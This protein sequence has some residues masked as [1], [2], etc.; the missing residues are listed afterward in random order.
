MAFILLLISS[1]FP[2]AERGVA[3][4]VIASGCV[5]LL[6]WVPSHRLSRSAAR[7]WLLFT[8]AGVVI[9]VGNAAAL[10]RGEDIGTR[11]TGSWTDGVFLLG[12]TLVVVGQF[13]LVSQRRA[14][15]EGDHALD[16]LL[17]GLTATS[18]VA[19]F[20]VLPVVNGDRALGI[21]LIAAA[22]A[23]VDVALVGGAARL[24]PGRG[25]TT[26][27]W[28]LLVG[29]WVGLI[30]LDL[31]PDGPRLP[32]LI[33]FVPL[34]LM[35]AAASH[36]SMPALTEGAVPREDPL[37]A[38]RLALLG[39][40]M[41]VPP[42]LLVTALLA[43]NREAAGVFAAASTVDG[44]MV[45][46]RLACLMRSKQ[47][48]ARR[49]FTL[50]MLAA[51][52][53][54]AMDARD[55][56]RSAIAAADQI[57]GPGAKTRIVPRAEALH[58]AAG[59]GHLTV[60]P[61]DPPVGL[62][63]ALVVSSRRPLLADTSRALDQLVDQVSLA[64]LSAAQQ[65]KIH[66][67]VSERRFRALIDHSSDLVAVVG[68]NGVIT[69]ASPSGERLLGMR[70]ELLVGLTL[71]RLVHH[72]DRD[73]A[74]SLLDAALAGEEAQ[75]PIEVRIQR[76]D[77]S[78]RWFEIAAS[79]FKAEKAE[80][81]LLNLRDVHLRKQ[82]GSTLA[83]REARFSALVRH[84][85]DLVLVLGDDRKIRWASPSSRRLLGVPDADLLGK[86]FA[87]LVHAEDNDAADE[88]IGSADERQIELRLS[89]ATAGWRIIALT[90]TDLRHV[91]AVQGIVLNARDIT[92]AKNLE[93][94]LRHR[95][96]YD[97]L[98]GLPNR[99]HFAEVV[100]S[101]LARSRP[102]DG[103]VVVMFIDLD[104]FKTVNDG[105]GHA[106]GDVVLNL[107][108]RRVEEAV[109]ANGT[110]ARLGGDE[111]AVL[112]EGP[113][114][115]RLASQIGLRLV[116]SLALPMR[117]EGSTPVQLSASVGIAANDTAGHSVSELLRGADIAMYLSKS[118]GKGRV[119]RY[120]AG[121][122]AAVFERLE[123][124]QDLVKAMGDDDQ[125][126]IAFQPVIDLASGRVAA[127]EALLRWEHP[128]R[129]QITPS[130]FIL[131]AEDTGLIHPLGLHVLEQACRQLRRCTDAGHHLDMHVNVSARQLDDDTFGTRFIETIRRY[132]LP[133]ASV[134]LELTEGI[135][136][137]PDQRAAL[138][139]L[140]RL[141]V[142]IAIDDF[143]TGYA[144]WGYLTDLPVDILKL[145]RSFVSCLG[146]Q[147]T[148][149]VVRAIIEV[150]RAHDLL[151]VAE[152]IESPGDRSVLVG[153]G[154][155]QGQGRLFADALSPE[156][157]EDYLGSISPAAVSR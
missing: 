26:R 97:G 157:L 98:T 1:A 145:D 85:S 69:F 12:C 114:A 148:L 123:M 34:V 50:R 15:A 68:P 138:E 39:L 79:S 113:D 101:A 141:G 16:A 47:E 18:A 51:D 32:A 77:G 48:A 127:L 64:L 131:L 63:V 3:G 121:M 88:V 4:L 119:E 83:E 66:G 130:A 118:R 31:W 111:F 156:Q 112:L 103:Q 56:E 153:L 152:G 120:E 57:A 55:I 78:W 6:G 23:V 60:R 80:G 124:K 108:A 106:A 20:V 36:P 91:P 105:L 100:E 59:S 11:P 104:D 8:M 21:R 76:L 41:L 40:A 107:A 102:A 96:H 136:P 142:R 115:A 134:V 29:G 71:L 84:A 46:Y 24:A 72:D 38:P 35:A 2:V 33:A 44:G 65:E 146:S 90:A 132:G 43:H 154:C 139:D 82:A 95:A 13:S 126:S 129:G 133:T 10:L 5:G 9:I 122:N 151:V 150:A 75:D 17:L 116:A 45:L 27:C 14:G 110:P 128:T 53:L 92:E 74:A 30:A 73:L 137:S 89:H 149:D 22:Y 28:Q 94:K 147:Q 25:A 37:T 155:H 143:G 135:P 54:R 117:V 19:A 99:V 70:A 42:G 93:E 144:S 62:P 58:S 125:I 67:Q 140:H 49:Q 7:P 52:L 61:F 81:L 87:D 86:P 109:A